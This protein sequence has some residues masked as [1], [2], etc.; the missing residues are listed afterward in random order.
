MGA[1]W[2]RGR[3]VIQMLA[4]FEVTTGLPVRRSNQA[5]I[6]M[7]LRRLGHRAPIPGFGRLLRS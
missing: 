1:R 5:S 7:T 2:P 3:S 4:W 6:W